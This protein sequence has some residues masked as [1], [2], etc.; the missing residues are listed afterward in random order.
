MKSVSK[1]ILPQEGTDASGV[2]ESLR[3]SARS[4]TESGR[5]KHRLCDSPAMGVDVMPG[6]GGDTTTYAE[7]Y[8]DSDN[9]LRSVGSNGP[10]RSKAGLP[11]RDCKG[12]ILAKHKGP[13]QGQPKGSSEG[14]CDDNRFA[15][16]A[17]DDSDTDLDTGRRCSNSGRSMV[18]GR[19]QPPSPTFVA[20]RNG[21]DTETEGLA[22]AKT[23]TA[24]KGKAR[25]ITAGPSRDRFLKPAPA[26]PGDTTTDESDVGT[27]LHDDL[28]ALDAQELRARAAEG[29]ASILEVAEKSGN[30]EG[31]FIA[32]LKRST[33]SLSEA[34]DAF[35]S[36]IESE[37]T[38]RLRAENHRLKL[39]KEALKAEVKALRRGIAEAKTEAVTASR[40]GPP[41]IRSTID[42]E[43]LELF[44]TRFV[45]EMI[46]VRLAAIEDRLPPAPPMRP[47]LRAGAGSPPRTT[48]SSAVAEAYSAPPVAPT[49]A[50]QESRVTLVKRE[51]K[52]RGKGKLDA[53]LAREAAI[54]QR[55]VSG[56]DAAGASDD[57]LTGISRSL[58][59]QTLVCDAATRKVDRGP[60]RLQPVYWSPEIE[61]LRAASIAARRK[62]LRCRR[63]K[64]PD[65][66]LE[67]EL[68]CAYCTAKK[69]LQLAISRGKE[70]LA[71]PAHV[72]PAMSSSSSRTETDSPLPPGISEG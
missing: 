16:L 55:W 39:E 44:L 23:N 53:E 56:R 17:V 20:G 10:A 47:P 54:V 21:S 24:R 12:R 7:R 11:S 1:K 52:W 8:S 34:V 64:P 22:L 58:A 40:A 25:G 59:S 4:P 19:K 51:K 46:N 13:S 61:Q 41:A 43:Q 28:C 27:P 26:W 66:A 57:D 36:R 67:A 48:A 69:A 71:G 62:Y 60:R 70:L 14:H 49:V 63:R 45:G 38:R 68:Q 30:L 35:V 32:R 50:P 29:L 9:S 72:P 33:T 15:A 42:I 37:E 31:K 65:P 6:R 2:G 5:G 18:G 3:A